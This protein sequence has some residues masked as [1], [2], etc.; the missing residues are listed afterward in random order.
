MKLKLIIL[1][2]TAAALVFPAIWLSHS[3]QVAAAQSIYAELDRAQL[4]RM[5]PQASKNDRYLIA[6]RYV[7]PRRNAW[8]VGYPCIFGFIANAILFGCIMERKGSQNN[9]LEATG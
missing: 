7:A 9:A 1:N 4:E 3:A 6:E 2:L 8:M 5:Y